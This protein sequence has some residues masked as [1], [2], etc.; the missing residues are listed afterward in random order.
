MIKRIMCFLLAMTVLCSGEIVSAKS[1]LSELKTGHAAGESYRT[2]SVDDCLEMTNAREKRGAIELEAGGSATFGFHI[3]YLTRAVKLNFEDA[4]GTVTI[5]T[6]LETDDEGE[7]TSY[8]TDDLDGLTEYNLVFGENKGIGKQEYQ[9]NNS[10]ASGYDREYVEHRGERIVKVTSSGGMTLH[11]LVFEKEY[12][13]SS[14]K[15][16]T[17]AV[18]SGTA[19]TYSTVF[20]DEDSSIIVAN[21]GRRYVDNNDTTAKPYEYNGRLYLPI[22][23]L[24]KALEYY[25]EDYPNKGYALMRSLTHEVVFLE[26]Q[27]TVSA[28]LAEP[29][30][31]PYEVF[32]YVN[33]KTYA[34][35]RYFAELIGDTVAYAD[36]LVIIDNKYTVEN[37]LNDGE[38]LSFAKDKFLQFKKEETK[39]N[40]YYVAQNHPEAN[41]NNNGTAVAPFKTLEQAANVARAGDTVIVKEG[42][43]REILKPKND[44]TASAPITFKAEEGEKVVISANEVLDGGWAQYDAEKNIWCTPM[45]WDLGITRNQLFIDNEMLTEARYPNGP[46]VLYDTEMLDAVWPVRGD[47]WRPAGKNT[48]PEW[49]IV[50]SP[51]LFWQKEKDYWKGGQY[52]GYF[53]Y[54]Y[55]THNA[56]IIGSDYGEL[57]L[58]DEKDSTW[59]DGGTYHSISYGYIVGIMNCL[60]APGEWVLEN[61]KIYMIFPEGKTPQTHTVEAKKRQLTIDLTNRNFVNVEGFDTI[62][63]SALLKDS[64]MC[65]LNGLNMKYISHALR[66][67]WSNGGELDFPYDSRNPSSNGSIQRGEDGVYLSGTDNIV[68]NC[69]LKY[70]GLAGIY[71]QGNYP[72]IEN[73]ILSDCGYTGSYVSGIASRPKSWES[74]TAP[75]GGFAI[76]NNTVYHCGRSA[77]NMGAPHYMQTYLPGESAY[78]DFHDAMITTVDSGITYDY[79]ANFGIDG[80]MSNMHHNYVYMTM[81]AQDKNPYSFGIYHDGSS[82]GFDTYRNQ[83]FGTEPNS[84]IAKT[85]TFMQSYYGAPAYYRKWD[86]TDTPYVP[87]G[88]DGLTEGYFTEERPHYAGALRDIETFEPIDYT[89]NYDRFKAGQYGMKYTV[90]KDNVTLSDGVTLDTNNGYAEFTGNDQYVKFA[91]VDFPENSGTVALALRG[92]SHYTKDVIEVIICSP[93]ADM[94]T[95]K[96]YEGNVDI[97]SYDKFI[98]ETL[99]IYIDST[100]G[101]KDVYVKVKEYKSVELGGIGVYAISDTKRPIQDWVAFTWGGNFD[102]KVRLEGGGGTGPM[103]GATAD[104][105]VNEL[106]AGW[107]LRYDDMMFEEAT[108]VLAIQSYSAGVYKG[109]QFE[110]YVDGFEEANLVAKFTED[111]DSWNDRALQAVKLDKEIS[112]GEHTIY[113]NLLPGADGSRSKTGTIL[114]FGFLKKDAALQGIDDL[115]AKV[116]GGMYNAE[117][118]KSDEKWP[119]HTELMDPPND[120]YYGVSYTLPGT[121]LAYTGVTTTADTTKLAVRYSG[122]KEYCGQPVEVRLGSPDGE[123]IASFTTSGTGYLNNKT[124]TYDLN[125]TLESGTYDVYICFGGNAGTIK[126]CNFSWF[127]FN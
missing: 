114:C 108:D 53:G 100:S 15:N 41:D 115:N 74:D 38:L 40:T 99:R 111:S 25:H 8:T 51:T 124:E 6:R 79:Q 92:D 1:Y 118:S 52:I 97:A 119:F 122:E 69:N 50:R 109:Q 102:E 94:S 75:F 16:V 73:N 89:K 61:N 44:G 104:P 125:R 58:G 71:L 127:G 26:G 30:P 120:A 35:V 34:A 13:P 93:G 55:S 116:Y 112:A 19:A 37:I 27:C 2:I 105:F 31:V 20:I 49:S 72:Y 82:H 45:T 123:V 11:S 48:T 80:Y 126:T 63:G 95:G 81:E 70:S 14:P 32:L 24:A 68:V 103:A 86:N 88:A 18:S 67:S 62:G 43:Y 7:W 65:M 117:S 23:T 29:E 76:Y 60:D 106:Y 10:T 90:S 77:Q 56:D 91:N 47:M 59:P 113:I 110:V 107:Y 33:G 21:G 101:T 57:Y 85:Y 28:G 42:V 87:G 83:V 66:M 78:N 4:K 46:E 54:A 84:G 3:P 96:V 39:G 121:Y 98:P 12:T 17:P 22:N 36:G 64:E 9:Y 5:E